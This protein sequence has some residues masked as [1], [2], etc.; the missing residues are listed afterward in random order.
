[1]FVDLE[2]TPFVYRT[3]GSKDRIE[4]EAHTRNRATALYGAWIDEDGAMLLETEHGVGLVDDRDLDTIIGALVGPDGAALAEEAL[5]EAM[6]RLQEGQ[7]APLWLK[8]GESDVTVRSIKSTDVP[9]RFGFT[10]QPTES[11]SQEALATPR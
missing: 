1:M 2:Y 9:A 10:P 3:V 11:P 5:D 7:D 6:S 8:V 4:V